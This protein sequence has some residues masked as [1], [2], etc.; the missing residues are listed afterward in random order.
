MAKQYQSGIKLEQSKGCLITS[1]TPLGKKLK[2]SNLEMKSVKCEVEAIGYAAMEMPHTR[3]DGSNR[4]FQ[5]PQTA[6]LYR[7]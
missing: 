5:Q 7:N 3:T 1:G 6:T 2:V 4:M